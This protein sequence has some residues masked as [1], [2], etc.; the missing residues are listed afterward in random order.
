MRSQFKQKLHSLWEPKSIIFGFTL[1]YYVTD[2]VIW[3]QLTSRL[4][5]MEVFPKP[6]IST[7]LKL[8]LASFALWLSRPWTYLIATLISGIII[9][10]H[11][12][13]MLMSCAFMN[14]QPVLSWETF[15]CWWRIVSFEA[16]QLLFQFA[17]AIFIFSYATIS[18]SRFLLHWRLRKYNIAK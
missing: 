15:N 7:P 9:Y 5:P 11:G 13:Q 4:G 3:A 6:W 16:P 1:F 2:Y 14:N 12:Y 10:S 8:L 17:L 18:L